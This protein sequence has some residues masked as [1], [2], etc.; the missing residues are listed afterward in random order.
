MAALWDPQ[1]CLLTT[2][3]AALAEIL[4]QAS[5]QPLPASWAHQGSHSC[6]NLA[7]SCLKGCQQN[8]LQSLAATLLTCEALQR[9]RSGGGPD[10]WRSFGKASA[11]E[12][13]H[14]TAADLQTALQQ[15]F[16]PAPLRAAGTGVLH[17]H[18]A[19]CGSGHP[20]ARQMRLTLIFWQAL[21]G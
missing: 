16:R 11:L 7:D 8:L 15:C 14:T 6:N 20:R 12:V 2:C 21:A 4:Q 19:G 9:C 17:T 18:V 13:K 5:Q 1:P 10:R 3:G